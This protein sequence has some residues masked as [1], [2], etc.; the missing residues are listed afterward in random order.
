L[1]FQPLSMNDPSML[2]FEMRNAVGEYI[3][4][5]NADAEIMLTLVFREKMNKY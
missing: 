4:F 5:S 1:D 2:H 3:T